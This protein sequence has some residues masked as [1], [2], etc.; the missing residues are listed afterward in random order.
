AGAPGRASQMACPSRLDADAGLVA[1]RA[2]GVAAA[3][4]GEAVGA[5]DRLVA[6]RLERHARLLAAL[7][8]GGGEHLAPAVAAAPG[9]VATRGI[10]AGA[11]TA[12]AVAAGGVAAGIAAGG[13]ARLSAIRAAARLV[14][15]AAAGVELLLAAGEGERSAAIAAGKGL[16][17]VTQR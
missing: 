15:E 5:V 13:A 9:G 10:P 16:V 14:G 1:R 12:G 11:I 3:L 8:A 6:A 2:R 4:L 7:R 17:C